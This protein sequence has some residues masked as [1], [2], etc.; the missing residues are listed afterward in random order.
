MRPRGLNSH[1]LRKRI[2]AWGLR[3]LELG[4]FREYGW[5]STKIHWDPSDRS[6]VSNSQFLYALC[7]D[8]HTCYL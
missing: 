4:G 7:L 1:A 3:Y 5:Y 2:Q 6:C 8:I